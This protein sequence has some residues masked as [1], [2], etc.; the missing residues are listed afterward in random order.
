MTP[1]AVDACPRSVFSRGWC[2]GHYERWRRTGDLDETRP[3]GARKQEHCLVDDCDRDHYGKGLCRDHWRRE[4][5]E[6]AWTIT[7]RVGDVLDVERGWWTAEALSDRLDANVETVS[8]ILWKLRDDGRLRSRVVEL[9]TRSS[10]TEF[11]LQ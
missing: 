4:R 3:I 10:Y 1:C 11:S 5:R 2:R 9:T 6:R 8:R 7:D